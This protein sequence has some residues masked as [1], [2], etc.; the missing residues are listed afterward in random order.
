MQNEF[1]L[2]ILIHRASILP[3]TYSSHKLRIACRSDRTIL[4]YIKIWKNR[5]LWKDKI[6]SSKLLLLAQI[7]NYFTQTKHK[8]ISPVIMY[9]E[10]KRIIIN[11]LFFYHS[12]ALGLHI[13]IHRASILPITYSS[14]KLVPMHSQFPSH[15]QS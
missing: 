13:M 4:S 1:D 5:P 9:G 12:I 11:K 7:N 15:L 14:H 8:I 3:I 2:H 10:R 6:K